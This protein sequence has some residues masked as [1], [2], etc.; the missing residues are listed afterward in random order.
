MK[1]VKLFV[2]LALGLM[3]LALASCRSYEFKGTEYPDPQPA[4]DFALD[5]VWGGSFRLSDYQGQVVLMYFGYTSCPDI[6]PATLAV[7]R[8]VLIELGEDAGRVSFLFVTVDPERDTPGVI[9]NYVSV[10]HPGIIGL[11]GTSEQ[12]QGVFDAY[13][14]VAEREE[15]PQSA[16]GYVMNHTTRTFLVDQAGRLRLSYAYGTPPEDILADV[17]HLLSE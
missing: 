15:L 16:V 8:K 13:G 5:N 1:R 6:C 7:A 10:F 12:L 3:A 9:A 17:H 14:I 4:P 2:C 11:T